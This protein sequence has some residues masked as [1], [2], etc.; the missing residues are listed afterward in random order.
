MNAAYAVFEAWERLGEDLRC[1]YKIRQDAI[2]PMCIAL[3]QDAEDELFSAATNQD[4]I[5]ALAMA[6]NAKTF[7]DS[8]IKDFAP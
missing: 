3:Y 7:I 1:A 5:F 2:G 4:F 8:Y 6:E